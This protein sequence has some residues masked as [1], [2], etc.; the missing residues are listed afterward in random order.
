MVRFFF[1][2]VL[3]FFI[4]ASICGQTSAPKYSNEFLAIGVGARGLA[5]SGN[6][7]ATVNDATAG[8]WNPAG[9]LKSANKY[10]LSIMHAEY[11]AGIAKYDYVAFSTPIDTVSHLAASIIRFA[12]DDI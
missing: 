11:F 9:L 8:Y 4:A 2:T 5:M 12:I 1:T 6:Q 10:E 3:S 7:V